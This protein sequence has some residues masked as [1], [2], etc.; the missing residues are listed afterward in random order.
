MQVKFTYETELRGRLLRSE[1]EKRLAE[2]Q[3]RK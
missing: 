1:G 2:P 3:N